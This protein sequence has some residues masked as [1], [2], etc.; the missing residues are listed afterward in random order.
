MR[1]SEHPRIATA[2]VAVPAQ[3]QQRGW[4]RAIAALVAVVGGMVSRE[5]AFAGV[6]VGIS[7]T[8][9][10]VVTVGNTNVAV[11]LSIVNTSTVPESGGTLTLSLIRHTP[12]CGTDAPVPC[13]AASADPG[14]FLIKG[15]ATGMAGT[16]CANMTFTIGPADPTTGEVEFIPDAPVVLAP[17]GS[18]DMAGCT[19]NFFVDVLKPPTIDSSSALPGLQTNQLG[20]VRALA[21]VNMVTGTGTGSG[22]TTLVEPT[23]TP[24]STPTNT[25]TG[26]PTPTFKPTDTATPTAT[27]TPT[28]TS[29][30][31][32]TQTP[33]K[34]PAPSDCCEC[35]DENHT[36][37]QPTAGQCGLIC[38]SGTPPVIHPNSACV[39][40]PPT[41][42]GTPST[43]GR[44]GCATY[45]AT[46][47]PT[48]TPTPNC[49]GTG[50]GGLP[51]LI[52]G[53][54]GPLYQD[55]LSEICLPSPGPVL[56]NGLPDNHLACSP[57]D[58]TCDAIPGD[59]ACTF[60]FRIC[61]NIVNESRYE[62]RIRGPVTLTYLHVP[63]ES[64]P[65]TFNIANVNAFEAAMIQLGGTISSFKGR[66]ISF[67]PPLAETVCTEPILWTVPLKQRTTSVAR[68]KV[69]INWHTFGS[70][71]GFDGDHLFLRCN[72]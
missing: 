44:G 36:C 66:S 51:D 40:P 17:V 71:R 15:P 19:I 14:V 33:T 50:P 57:D 59:Q 25:P 69:R 6:G 11:G 45:T 16:A 23:P 28:S 65:K 54:C 60:S 64:K 5:P 26:T 42:T 34:T 67:A 12:S 3:S 21:S 43:P 55:C 1:R 27:Q 37:A 7:P 24:T 39:A 47:T 61:F 56:P 9:P 63:N 49:L 32:I 2:V 22:I 18:G 70:T 10:A 68:R 48:T 13:P 35:A 4:L 58:P 30:P 46:P 20:R 62:C 8:Y 52:P 53:Y 29:T 38:P 72:P 31:T 41:T